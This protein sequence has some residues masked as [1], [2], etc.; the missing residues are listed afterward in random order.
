[1]WVA[2]L[3]LALLAASAFGA[4]V[5]MREEAREVRRPVPGGECV[6]RGDEE[7]CIYEL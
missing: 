2:Y 1:V 4:A 7:H 5:M 3:V 6:Q